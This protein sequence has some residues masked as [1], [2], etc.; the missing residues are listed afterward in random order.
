MQG[1]KTGDK[2]DLKMVTSPI[3]ITNIDVTQKVVTN[4]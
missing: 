3:S 2:D 4:V 1:T